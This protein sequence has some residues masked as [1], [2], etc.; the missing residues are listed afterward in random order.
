MDGGNAAHTGSFDEG[1]PRGC[2]QRRAL[3][4]AALEVDL[5]WVPKDLREPTG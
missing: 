5:I 1:G 3:V 4:T 2:T